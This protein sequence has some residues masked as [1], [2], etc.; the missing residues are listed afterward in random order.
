ML[1]RTLAIVKP[2]AV[3]KHVI[4]DIVR[5]YEEAG[6]LPIAMRML[7]LSKASAEG[8]YAVHRERPFFNDL[9]TYMCSGPVVVVVLEGK[10]AVKTNRDLMGATDPKQAAPG[11]IRALYGASI[12]ANVVHGS[13]SPE[14]AQ[15]EIRYFFP[16]SELR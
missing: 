8:F 3:A 1:E 10:D 12:E 16:E 4:G 9:T 15:I 5:R 2:D 7:H 13:D 6:L 14:N 11:T